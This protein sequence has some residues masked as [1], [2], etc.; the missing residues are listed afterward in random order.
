MSMSSQKKKNR[1][2]SMAKKHPDDTAQGEQDVTVKQ[3]DATLD[4]CPGGNRGHDPDEDR[5]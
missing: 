3:S 4:F 2:R 5:Q 1:N